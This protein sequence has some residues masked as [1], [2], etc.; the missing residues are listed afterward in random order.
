MCVCGDFA[1]PEVS[2]TLTNTH[3][4]TLEIERLHLARFY[5]LACASMQMALPHTVQQRSETHTYSGQ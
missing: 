5:V 4:H 3:T 2:I 1:C